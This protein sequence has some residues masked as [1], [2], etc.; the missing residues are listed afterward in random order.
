MRYNGKTRKPAQI[1]TV[2]TLAKNKKIAST[3]VLCF[4]M[5]QM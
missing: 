3:I 1:I 2:T 4:T 5:Q